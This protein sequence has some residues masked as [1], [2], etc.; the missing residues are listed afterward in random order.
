MIIWSGWGLLTVLFA[1]IGVFVGGIVGS[2]AG[3]LLGGIVGGGVAAVVN[4]LVAKSLGGGKVLIDPETQQPVLLKKNNSLFS[5]PMSWFTPIYAVAGIFFGAAGMMADQQDKEL[6][7]KYPGKTVFGKAEKL[8]NSARSGVAH[9]NNPAAEKAAASFGSL[10]KTMQSISF[11]GGKKAESK[12]FV[13]Y[14][15]QGKDGVTFICNVPDLRK[16]KDDEA[17][18]ALAE[19]AWHAANAAV[20]E[21][22]PELGPECTVTVG[23]RGITAYGSIQQG[24]LGSENPARHDDEKVFYEIFDPGNE[25]AE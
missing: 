2:F 24:K 14:C 17:K 11:T 16:Y 1:I 4:H 12:P 8:I 7:G 10:L 23:L 22:F 20:Q 3:A 5:I 21:D 13:S 19:L 25:L 9:G 6:D 18:A 15:H